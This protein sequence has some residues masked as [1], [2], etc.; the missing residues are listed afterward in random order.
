MA[1]YGY[2]SMIQ[3]FI[4]DENVHAELLNDFFPTVCWN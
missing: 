2:L 4:L 3:S 1:E